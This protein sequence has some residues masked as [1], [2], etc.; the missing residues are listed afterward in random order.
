METNPY[1]S[2]DKNSTAEEES[3]L[4][5]RLIALKSMYNVFI[6]YVKF[7]YILN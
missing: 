2:N 7:M 3:L 1:Y 6:F 5:E 4:L